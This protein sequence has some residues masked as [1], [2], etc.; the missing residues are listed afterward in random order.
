MMIPIPS[1]KENTGVQQL[2]SFS[3]LP[4]LH[5]TVWFQYFAFRYKFDRE[6]QTKYKGLLSIILISSSPSPLVEVIKNCLYF[7]KA[8]NHH[9]ILPL[10]S[11]LIEIHCEYPSLMHLLW[12]LFLRDSQIGKKRKYQ[13]HTMVKII[14]EPNLPSKENVCQKKPSY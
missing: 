4:E 6:G 13:C 11:F 3:F 5:L 1:T 14:N 12:L 8:Y 7:K 9:E 2:S 10:R